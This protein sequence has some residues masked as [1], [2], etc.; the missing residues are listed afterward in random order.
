M[1]TKQLNYMLPN[2][3]GIQSF[4]P[5]LRGTSYP[6]S[7]QRELG[8][9]NGVVSDST[10]WAAATPLGLGNILS[11]TQGSLHKLG[12]PGLEDAIPLGLE[13]CATSRRTT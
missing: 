1:T 7:M 12:N 2:P 8:N 11:N 5:G 6:G 3:N 9:P 13:I 4:S 10:N